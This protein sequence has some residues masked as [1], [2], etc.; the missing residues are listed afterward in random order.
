MATFSFKTKPAKK[1]AAK[2]SSPPPKPSSENE[3]EEIT[4]PDGL[5]FKDVAIDNPALKELEEKRLKRIQDQSRQD[6]KVEVQHYV[7]L[8][9]DS[10]AQKTEF[11]GHIPEVESA[12]EIYYDGKQ[13]A[14]KFGIKLHDPKIPSHKTS[15]IST[16]SS[17]VDEEA[18]EAA[19]KRKTEKPANR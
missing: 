17:L 8:V 15:P 9:F 10:Y 5:T 1:K 2:K 3:P 12:F 4:T 19:Y 16:W 11:V 6:D 18:I 14:E 7:V 13:F